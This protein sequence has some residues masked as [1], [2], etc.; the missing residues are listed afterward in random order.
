MD[1]TASQLV[2]SKS[3][4]PDMVLWLAIFYA[5]L[6]YRPV[7][8]LPVFVPG[9]RH[10]L[11]PRVMFDLLRNMTGHVLQLLCWDNGHVM[12]QALEQDARKEAGKEQ[13]KWKAAHIISELNCIKIETTN[14]R[15]H[16]YKLLVAAGMV[17]PEN[18][19]NLH[20][21]CL[22]SLCVCMLITAGCCSSSSKHAAS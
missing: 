21:F 11:T 15:P 2:G 14:I 3:S 12:R 4:S 17:Q 18:N 9:N 22:C 16:V 10:L 7:K 13:D 1:V 20:P 8:G 19:N 5:E 6:Q